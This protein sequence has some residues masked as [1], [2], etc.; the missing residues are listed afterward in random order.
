[1]GIEKISFDLNNSSSQKVVLIFGISSFVG[2]NLAEVLKK[3]FKVVGT[4]FSNPVYIDGVVTYPC[5]VLKK[6]DVQMALY[7][8][9]PDLTIY[10]AGLSSVTA[11]DE[12][13][14]YADALNSGGLFNVTEFCQ[15]YKSQICYI[16]SCYVFGGAN[17]KYI[18]TDIPD[19][20]SLYGKTKATAEFFVQKTSLDYMVFRCCNFYGRGINKKKSNW[21]EKLENSIYQGK[22]LQWDNHVKIGFLDI[23]YLGFLIKLC[24]E[25]MVRN[26]V[27]QVSSI[28]LMTHYEFVKLYSEVFSHSDSSITKGKWHFPL[29]N[30]IEMSLLEEMRFEMDLSNMESFLNIKLPS[31]RESLE[32]TKKRFRLSQSE[33]SKKS[34]KGGAITYI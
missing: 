9:R 13:V 21:F 1:M 20:A 25:N 31:I 24:F 23:Y 30:Y 8:F 29:L 18:E 4:Y 27:F 11:C 32:F 26:R 6:D 3:D 10:S 33:S 17:R 22:S 12:N 19:S 34:K 16:S 2:S 7:T 14:E 5:D 15:R 28:D